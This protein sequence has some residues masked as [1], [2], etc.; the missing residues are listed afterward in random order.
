MTVPIFHFSLGIFELR[1]HHRV[2]V[3]KP[4]GKRRWEGTDV[5]LYILLLPKSRG[6]FF[7]HAVQVDCTLYM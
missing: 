2:L 7:Y 6:K 1:K 5:D 3:G 4:E